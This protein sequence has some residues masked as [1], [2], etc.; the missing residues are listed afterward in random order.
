MKNQTK[1]G[2]KCTT[3]LLLVST[4]SFAQ[5]TI[6]EKIETGKTLPVLE[7]DNQG[8]LLLTENRVDFQTWQS[9]SKAKEEVQII[10]YLPGTRS[11]QQAFK[12]ITDLLTEKYD[13]SKL[14][15]TTIINLDDALWGTKSL[16]V[17]E[18]KKKKRLH[19]HST[20]V[21]DEEGLGKQNWGLGEDSLAFMVVDS[22]NTVRYF[23]DSSMTKREEIVV[24]EIVEKHIKMSL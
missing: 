18:A 19:P 16:V 24:M 9:A 14:H 8:E 20:M 15:V 10:R 5:P 4:L 3:A 13:S 12:S 7:L 21:L 23:V 17:S 22:T 6:P 11:A 2:L 1:I